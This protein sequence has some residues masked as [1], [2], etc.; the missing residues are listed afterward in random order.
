[1]Y[2]EDDKRTEEEQRRRYE[3]RRE[4]QRKR[5]RRQMILHCLMALSVVVLII[6][7]I[8]TIRHA[9]GKEA[10]MEVKIQEPVKYVTEEPDIRVELIDIN[11]YSRP[12]IA[13]EEVTGVVIH[14]TA[15]PGTTAEQNRGY[16]QSLAE[17]EETYASSHFIVGIEGEIIQCIPCNEIAYASKE[18]NVDTIS[19]ECCIPDETGKF[20]DATYESLVEL[21]AWLMG[22]YE[23]GVDDVIRHYDVTG[24]DCP[25]YYVENEAAWKQ[26]KQDLMTYIDTN[27]IEKTEEIN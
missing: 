23:L 22:R 21:T 4:R 10:T 25:K 27:G 14:Y 17:T 6:A 3:A 12:A 18:R 13:L 24:K 11:E 15:N 5:R 20:S 16:F 1:M 9:K 2:Y 8:I 26:F 19:I 7:I